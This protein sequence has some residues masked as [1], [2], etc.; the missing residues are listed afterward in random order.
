MRRSFL[1][2][3]V[4]YV[5]LP[6][7]FVAIV[8]LLAPGAIGPKLMGLGTGLLV[9]LIA[10]VVIWRVTLRREERA[11][12]ENSQT[13]EIARGGLTS[14]RRRDIRLRAPRDES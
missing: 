14:V 3:F 4:R 5:G 1:G 12:H 11:S 8:I 6:F 13:R 2:G 10:Y 7:V 9:A